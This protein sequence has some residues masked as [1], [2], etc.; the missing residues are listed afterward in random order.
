M[1]LAS[2]FASRSP[3]LRSVYPLTDDQIHRVAPPIFADAPHES[4]S[5]RYAYIPP[6]P[7]WPSFARKDSSSKTVVGHGRVALL[8]LAIA[9]NG[10]RGGRGSGAC[11]GFLNGWLSPGEMLL[12]S[13]DHL[14]GMS[15][16]FGTLGHFGDGCLAPVKNDVG[17]GPREAAPRPVIGSV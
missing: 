7:W 6:P 14:P 8:L 16:T 2:R 5:Q 3:S 13:D 12:Q 1:Q 17:P 9:R 15:D 11:N 10:G 4:R